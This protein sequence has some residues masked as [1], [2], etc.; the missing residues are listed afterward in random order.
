MLRD[1]V[2]EANTAQSQL[3]S[4]VREFRKVPEVLKVACVPPNALPVALII[5]LLPVALES[6]YGSCAIRAKELP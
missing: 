5:P 1:L 2:P 6:E 3:L 4:L